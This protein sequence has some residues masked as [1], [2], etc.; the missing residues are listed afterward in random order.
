M[1]ANLEV[2][3]RCFDIACYTQSGTM[4]SAK[5]T[6]LASFAIDFSVAGKF[7]FVVKTLAGGY[8]LGPNLQFPLGDITYTDSTEPAAPSMRS[9]Y[10]WNGEHYVGIK[11]INLMTS[12]MNKLFKVENN[13]LQLSL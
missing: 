12:M 2:E 5:T 4:N 9:T 11:P 1:D 7:G 13:R 10:N 8:N 3:R 6:A